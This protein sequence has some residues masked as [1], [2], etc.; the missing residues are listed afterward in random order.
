MIVDGVDTNIASLDALWEFVGHLGSVVRVGF[1]HHAAAHR[2][3]NVTV[4]TDLDGV[5]LGPPSSVPAA[6]RHKTSHVLHAAQIHLHPFALF[7][8]CG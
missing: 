2:R 6:L 5:R 8:P 1:E 3:P 7:E 4:L